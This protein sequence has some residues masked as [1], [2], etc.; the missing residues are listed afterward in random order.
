[1][2]FKNKHAMNVRKIK[3]IKIL[4][5]GIILLFIITFL[6]PHLAIR[7]YALLHL[8]P[9]SSMKAK[10]TN[11]HH[12]DPVYGHLFDVTGYKDYQTGDEL[13]VFYLK[14]YWI[15]WDVSSVGTG[16]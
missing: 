10:I 1:M 7:R 8:H 5:F 4:I 2:S 9:I 16:P 13:G 6:S 12:I 3:P 14:K 15:F 11:T